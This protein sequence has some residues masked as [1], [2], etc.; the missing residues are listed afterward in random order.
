MADEKSNIYTDEGRDDMQEDD[1]IDAE[2]AGFMQGY[3]EGER[4]AK[5]ALCKAVLTEDF[6]E[7]D[8][9]GE[10]YRF[11]CEEHANIFVKKKN[12]G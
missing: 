8:I 6:Y 5:C 9:G 1:S 4:S 11:C 7:E 12:E 2:E 10:T 3:E